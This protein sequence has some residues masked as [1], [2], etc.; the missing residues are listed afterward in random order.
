MKEGN[1][2]KWITGRLRKRGGGGK[3][4]EHG[5][6]FNEEVKNEKANC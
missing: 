3:E 6:S 4:E 2:G 5:K 1:E